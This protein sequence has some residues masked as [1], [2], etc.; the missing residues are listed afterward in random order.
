MNADIEARSLRDLQALHPARQADA[1][2]AELEQP[3]STLTLLGGVDKDGKR[4]DLNLVIAVG[5]V[6]CI[7]GPT[8]SGKSRLL[9]DIECLAQG[10]TPS[11]RSVLINGAAPGFALRFGSKRRLIAQLSQNMNFVMDLSVA[12]FLNMHAECRL[13]ATPD[14]VVADII[15]CANDL[16]GEPFGPDAALTQLSGGQSRALM[17]A[18]TALLSASPIVLIDE[19]ENAGIDRRKALDLLVASEKIVLIS[20]HD[21]ILALMGSRRIV[22]RNG[23]VAD[24]IGT[25]SAER[26]CLEELQRMDGRIMDIRRR[27]RAGQRIEDFGSE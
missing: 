27:L 9:G 4:E 23:A 24:V 26:A 7:V 3:L 8:G 10:D 13:T 11:G 21:P 16:A 19:I 17:I 6:V 15:A 18:D 1:A 25:S 5:E 12:E 14:G 20:T 22:I 2:R